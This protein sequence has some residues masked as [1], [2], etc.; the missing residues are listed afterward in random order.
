MAGSVVGCGKCKQ[1]LRIPGAE[2]PPE[3][4]PPAPAP[5]PL[6]PPRAARPPRRQT[7]LIQP[8]RRQPRRSRSV[9]PLVVLCF[10]AVA[11]LAGGA[12]YLWGRPR[13]APRVAKEDRPEEGRFASVEIEKPAAKENMDKDD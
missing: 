12:Y 11:G 10:F 5:P 6:P 2:T 3:P 7:P 8:P 4:R 9:L 13:P 1:T